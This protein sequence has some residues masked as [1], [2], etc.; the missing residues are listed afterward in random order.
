[1]KI[2]FTKMHGAGNDFIVVF[3]QAVKIPRTPDTIRSMCSRN[4][5][6]GA[7]GLI[8]LSCPKRGR[9]P[10]RMDFFNSDGSVA[11]MCGNGLR[12]AGLFCQRKLDG[13][14][15]VSI[16][17]DSGIL[18]A[19]ITGKNTV[20]VKIPVREKF[21]E[22]SIEREKMY[23]G[24]T[25]VPHLV[26]PVKD[27]KRTDVC[28][29]GRKLRHH[30]KFSPA[31][32][33]VNFISIPDR[34]PS[35]IRTYERGV[36]GETSACGTGITASAVVLLEFFGKSTPLEFITAED[37]I[38]KVEFCASDNILNTPQFALLTGP[39]IEVYSGTINI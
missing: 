15:K 35:R 18:D 32:T 25:G 1:M 3:E 30:R 21:R 9:A 20:Q 37:D 2:G 22:I 36:E 17:T 19:T 11:G 8:I 12:C 16:S 28:G 31:G 27:I 24:N 26:V 7:D 39:A 23:F 33:N 38:L 29:E 14:R 5:G 6:I 4:R 13:G 34:G 10:F